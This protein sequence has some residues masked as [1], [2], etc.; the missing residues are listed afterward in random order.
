MVPQLPQ[1]A[2]SRCVS[3]QVAAQVS[4]QATPQPVLVQVAR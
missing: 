3:T 1:F 4:M 2:A